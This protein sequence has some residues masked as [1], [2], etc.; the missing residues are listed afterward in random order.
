MGPERSALRRR[1]MEAHARGELATAEAAYR[2]ILVDAPED[3]EAMHYLGALLTGRGAPAAL[4]ALGRS[5]RLLP[6]Q[7]VF[8]F[9]HALALRTAGHDAAA[10]QE[11]VVAIRHEPGLP[12]AHYHLGLIRLAEHRFA[13][14]ARAFEAAVSSPGLRDVCTENLA[15]I[16][17]FHTGERS[18][19]RPAAWPS[20]PLVSVVIPCVNHGQFV[21]DAVRSAL[22]QT[23]ANIEVVVVE[24]GST[25]G[26]TRAAVAALA[27][28]RLRTLFRSPRRTVGDNRN[29]GIGAARGAFVCCL[30]ADDTLAPDYVEKAMFCLETLGYDVAGSGVQTFGLMEARRNF[31]RNPTVDDFLVTN[32]LSTAA[33]L[34]RGVWERAGGFFD[35]DREHGFVHED[36]NFWTRVAALGARIVNINWEHLIRYRQ[37]AAERLTAKPTILPLDRQ[38]AIIRGNNGDVLAP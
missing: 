38:I 12:E 4:A 34:R 15:Y 9:N 23:Y 24:G 14:A 5:V 18:F 7:G 13:E 25:D 35:H 22:G 32:Q 10:A 3:A 2:A 26:T 21:A 28:P 11:L 31:I 8:R 37:H 17:C 6:E 19:L 29:F 33:L 1:A 16:R 20:P 30:D 27:H 36:W